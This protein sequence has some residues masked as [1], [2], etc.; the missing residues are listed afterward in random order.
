MNANPKFNAALA[1]VDEAAVQPLPHS[2]KIYVERLARRPPRADAR[3]RAGRHAGV[4]RRREEPA[5]LRLRHLG[6]VHRPGGADR[7]P[8]GPARRCA[9][10]GSTSAATPRSSAGPTLALRPRAARRPEAR[11]AALRPASASRAARRPGAQRHPDALRAPRHRHAG[12][13]VRRDP[14]EP[15]AR[16]TRALRAR[17]PGDAADRPPAS[18]AESFGAA[19][20]RDD[21]A[22]VRARRGRARPRDHPGQHQPPGERADDHRPQLPG[23]DQRQHRQLGGRPRRS[24]RRSRR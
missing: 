16:V 7:H 17:P 2:R 20:P 10:R 11:R 19:I 14:R 1:H 5:D 22:R 4:V 3:D 15:A 13:G 21:H 12:D 8:P 18:R 24:R 23:E 6:P 9:R